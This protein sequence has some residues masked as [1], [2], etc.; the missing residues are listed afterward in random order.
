M[1]LHT[2]FS[3]S[4]YFAADEDFDFWEYGHVQDLK[5]RLS[6]GTILSTIDFCHPLST[7]ELV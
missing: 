3:T 1:S 6:S 4:F 7:W 2:I 5:H